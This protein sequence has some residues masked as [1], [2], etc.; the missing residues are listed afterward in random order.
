MIKNDF[1]YFDDWIKFT[2]NYV[3]KTKDKIILFDNIETM[4][5]EFI[6]Q[7][8]NKFIKKFSDNGKSYYAG[9]FKFGSYMLTSEGKKRL[10]EIINKQLLL[11]I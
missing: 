2:Y 11:F 3:G 5:W 7:C 1:E 9:K 8:G 4:S 6:S 10:T